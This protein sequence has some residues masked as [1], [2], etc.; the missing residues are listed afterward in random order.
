MLAGPTQCAASTTAR[1]PLTTW[2]SGLSTSCAGTDGVHT[3][4]QS[5]ERRGPCGL[6]EWLQVVRFAELPRRSL[7]TP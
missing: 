6:S 3:A 5:A 2:A 1:S 7:W 4:S